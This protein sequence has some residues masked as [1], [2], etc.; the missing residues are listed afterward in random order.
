MERKGLIGVLKGFGLKVTPQ[1]IEVFEAVAKLRNH[2]TAENINKYIK[3]KNPN[4]ATGTIYN[5]LETLVKCGVIV[6]VKT[7]ND[8]MRY[9][10]VLEKHH[11]LYSAN[12]NRIEDY[13]DPELDKLIETHFKNKMIPD[14]KIAD[15]KLQIV[16]NF[17]DKPRKKTNKTL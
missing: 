3:S 10:A 8:I 5:N 16:G 13:V 9:D 12:S 1:R 15:I 6:K 7:D 17:T 2:P 4:I 11:H 14:F